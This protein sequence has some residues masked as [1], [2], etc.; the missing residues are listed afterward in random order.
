MKTSCESMIVI[1]LVAP[2]LICPDPLNVQCG[3]ADFSNLVD[4]WSLTAVA[5]DNDNNPIKSTL[6]SEL[7][8]EN[9]YE[10]IQVT[11][12]VQNN[13][14]QQVE[15]QSYISI[16]DEEAPSL[17]CPKEMTIDASSA[18]VEQQILEWLDEAAA[19]DCNA[20]TIEHDLQLDYSSALC[21]KVI[22]VIFMAKDI[23]DL[24]SSCESLL[25]LKNDSELSVLCPDPITVMCSD[26]GLD[27][28]VDQHLSLVQVTAEAPYELT[29][30]YDEDDFPGECISP[31][32]L[33]IDV[34]L[35]GSC[36][37]EVECQ[38]A[39]HILPEPTIYIPNVFSPD[40][41]GLNDFF[42]VYSNSSI[43]EVKSM[44][45]YD[46]WGNLVF[47]TNNILPNVDK[48]GWN[49]RYNNTM[50]NDNVYTYYLVLID[51]F[52]TEIEKVGTVQV[53]K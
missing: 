23:C 2:F 7:P 12:S 6:P 48:D 46:K 43:E 4:A 31:N 21:S 20:F 36:N 17:T 10:E 14:Q 35:M 51:T 37:K 29:S 3:K 15:C 18:I 34:H 50:G 33:D 1:Q 26:P 52:G 45:I 42:T 39:I 8:L 53:L 16:I 49:G 11:F 32:Q 13:C 19:T 5:K 9:C 40:R 25:N 22:P 47:E 24:T 27:Y 41:D 44:L 28:L 30:Y 38:T